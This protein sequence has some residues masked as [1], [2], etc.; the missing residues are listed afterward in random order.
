MA[1]CSQVSSL[2]QAYIDGELGNAEKSILEQHLRECPSCRHDLG[3]QNACSA[4]IFESLFTQRLRGGLRSQVLDHLPEMDPAPRM[5]S[6]PTDPQYARRRTR[7]VPFPRMLLVA[8]A[9][10]LTLAG[11]YFYTGETAPSSV[12]PPAVGMVT[13]SNGNEVFCKAGEDETYVAAELK[14]LVRPGDQFET[15]AKGRLAISLIGGSIVK[16][17]YSSG[18]TIQDNRRVSVE[19]GLTFFDVGR[20]KR[21]FN[22]KTPG[23]EILV[24]GTAFV[25]EVK[26]DATKVTVTEGDILVSNDLGKT[27]VSKGN[28]LVFRMGEPLAEPYPVD[29]AKEAAWA[30]EIVPDPE[31]L[32]L[33]RQTLESRAAI[34][35]SIPAIPVY[36]VWNLADR[37]ISEI[38]ITWASDGRATGHCGYIVH[39]SDG[40]GNLL[41]IDTLDGS[42]FDD[43]NREKA[44]LPLPG[45]PVTGIDVIHVKLVPD[46]RDGTIETEMRVD[47]V[48]TPN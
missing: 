42:L 11:L 5:G 32:A 38:Q 18:L 45:G 34:N 31:A 30:D 40:Q 29:A 3:E 48:V 46:H 39:V 17:N 15:L 23:G 35:N 44:N 6:H 20:D 37:H 9:A 14:S 2:L 33:F 4:K 13:Y 22:V 24:F 47:V 26:S 21:L 7:V 1:S 41:Y 43:V 10:L 36:A 25:V 12:R 28:Q 8:A 16:A 19:Q 27:G